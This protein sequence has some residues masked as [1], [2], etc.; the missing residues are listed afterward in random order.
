[1][2]FS[3]LRIAV[4]GTGSVGRRHARNLLELGVSNVVLC[5]EFQRGGDYLKDL[6][7]LPVV[8]NYDEL[9]G[10]KLNAVVIAN[11]SNLHIKYALKALQKDLPIYLEKPAGID[12]KEIEALVSLNQSKKAVI[13]VGYQ[14]RFNELLGMVKSF[15]QD[16]VFGQIVYVS[17]NM[18]EYLPYYHPDEDYRKGYAAKESMGGG[19]LRTQIHD[20]NYLRWILGELEIIAAHGGKVSQLKIDVEDSVTALLKTVDNIPVSLHMDYL[21]KKAYRILE[22]VGV[23]GGLRWD[24]HNNMITKWNASGNIEMIGAGELDRK[25]LFLECMQDFLE[26]VDTNEQP[27]SNLQDGYRDICLVDSLKKSIRT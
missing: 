1:M 16:K 12:A 4:I 20:I 2:D 6:D 14:H 10:T 18:G 9:L 24:Y 21:Q 27:K 13:A 26:C 22:I 7:N 5:S 17:C 19:V 8:K 3:K 23:E 25:K 15:Y 11:A